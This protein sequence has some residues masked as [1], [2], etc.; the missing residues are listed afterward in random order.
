MTAV[1]CGANRVGPVQFHLFPNRHG[2]SDGGFIEIGR[3]GRRRRVI[4]QFA[5]DPLVA[6]NRRPGSGWDSAAVST[7][8][9]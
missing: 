2:L 3:T 5:Q 4:G 6:Q 1:A 9:R 7:F 8:G